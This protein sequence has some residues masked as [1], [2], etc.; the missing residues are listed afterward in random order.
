MK[1]T[2]REFLAAGGGA[3]LM[4]ALGDCRHFCEGFETRLETPSQS[5]PNYWCTWDGQIE[6]GNVPLCG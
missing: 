5:S 6:M 4:L 2:R 1:L 3:G